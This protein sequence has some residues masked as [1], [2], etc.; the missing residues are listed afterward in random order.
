M[1]RFD[2]CRTLKSGLM[3]QKG[4]YGGIGVIKTENRIESALDSIY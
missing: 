4:G 3:S 1:N 2:E